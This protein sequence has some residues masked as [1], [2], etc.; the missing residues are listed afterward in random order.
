MGSIYFA[1]LMT[2]WASVGF[3]EDNFLKASANTT[4]MWVKLVAAWITA[5]LYCWSLIAPRCCGDRD[6]GHGE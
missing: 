4:S 1:M 6:F 5:L 2:N 3:G